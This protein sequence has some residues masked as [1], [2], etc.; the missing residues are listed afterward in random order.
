MGKIGKISSI[1][2]NYPTGFETLE[3]SLSS[4]GYDRFPGTYTMFL[5]Y[6][7]LSGRYRTGL[8]P[9]APF[10]NKLSKEEAD[11]KRKALRVDL[12]RLEEATGLDL[13][14]RSQYY[15]YGAKPNIGGTT[16][17][18]VKAIKIYQKDNIF[19]LEN[20]LQEITYRW[21]SA[22][23]M[24]ASS[25]K[26][27]EGGLYPSS[28]QFYVNNEEVEQEMMFSKK[29]LINKA[30]AVLERLS[31]ERRKK[32]SRLL[33][34]PVSDNTSETMVYN[35]LDSFIK[36][37][38]VKDGAFKGQN[39]IT[40]FNRFSEMDGKLLDL[41]DL[42]E[43]AI[44]HSIYRVKTGGRIHEGEAEIFKTK[45]ELVDYLYSDKGQEDLLALQDK[46]SA[47]K[48]TLVQ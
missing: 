37:G 4:K 8:D 48:S 7:E 29:I 23:P 40:L 13:S 31:I 26:A 36:D 24:I 2:K 3:S 21:L 34:L 32:I 19:N 16:I 18:K 46:L 9:D 35:L 43:Q 25:Y 45:E 41:K 47:K 42:V 30:V 1:K 12:K 39:S 44:T 20:A 14:P 38:D 6:R 15:N 11:I 10:L 5:P 27:W 28:T 22:H 17:E 33:G